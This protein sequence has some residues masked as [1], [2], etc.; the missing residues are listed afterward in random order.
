MYMAT[1]GHHS[2][3]AK[4]V[5]SLAGN[6]PGSFAFSRFHELLI[7]LQIHPINNN[8]NLHVC[9]KATPESTPCE[10]GIAEL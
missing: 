9:A 6:Q 5:V 1:L 2:S 10:I 3:T 4:I 7:A 8:Q